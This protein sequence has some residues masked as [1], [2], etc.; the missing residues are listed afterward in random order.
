VAELRILCIDDEDQYFANVRE[1]LLVLD[2]PYSLEHVSTLDDAR[3]ALFS[4][5]YCIAIIDLVLDKSTELDHEQWGGLILLDEIATNGLQE[6]LPAVIVTQF[7][8]LEDSRLAF[9]AHHAEDY[10]AKTAGVADLRDKLLAVFTRLKW[11]GLDC[12]VIQDDASSW[13]ALTQRVS[14]GRLQSLR[15]PMPPEMAAEEMEHVFRRLF[16]ECSEV[17][18]ST[19]TGGNTP[20][21]VLAVRWHLSGDRVAKDAVAKL[22]EVARIEREVSGWNVISD[23][24]S[25]TRSTV[26]EKYCRG[27]YTSAVRYAFLGGGGSALVPFAEYYVSADLSRVERTVQSLFGD[28]CRLF[29]D[30]QN[31]TRLA[32]YDV[33]ESYRSAYWLEGE[34]LQRAYEFK[35]G[36]PL[37]D[38]RRFVH[39]D[40]DTELPNAVLEFV[41]GRIQY[42]GDSYTCPTHGDLHGGNILVDS[43]QGGAWLIDF[44]ASGEGHWAR[45][46]AM[47][48][49]YVR[50]I[51]LGTGDLPSLYMFEHALANTGSLDIQPTFHGIL[52]SDLRRAGTIIASIRQYAASASE[53][54]SA[55]AAFADYHVALIMTSLRYMQLHRL[56]NRK[57]RKHQVMMCAG[58][59][60][61]SLRGL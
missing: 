29:Y 27:L 41:E 15:S 3:A 21:G 6:Y 33:V 46:F 34:N 54:L 22:G 11:F 20:T 13:E 30:P 40:L 38:R 1:A 51:L 26:V 17:H 47:L 42:I 37:L 19:L 56:L 35:F 55:E 36:H 43:V 61:N 58:V 39:R 4:Q 24:L 5:H 16:D 28:T 32:G 57:W 12:R 45:D 48:E 53:L 10:I 60:L 14:A 2:R 23:Y 49:C 8:T 31:L 44:G 7:P 52:D 25:G 18:I 50:Y 59:F 9:L